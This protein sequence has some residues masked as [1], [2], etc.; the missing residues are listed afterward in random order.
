MLR[1][2]FKPSLIKKKL[3]ANHAGGKPESSFYFFLWKII[4]SNHCHMNRQSKNIQLKYYREYQAVNKKYCFYVIFLY[5]LMF[6]EN[7]SHLQ[8][9]LLQSIFTLNILIYYN[10]SFFSKYSCIYLVL[11]FFS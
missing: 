1:Q 8:I 9:R 6:T 4:L 2:F 5:F 10:M 3:G 7:V 11:Y